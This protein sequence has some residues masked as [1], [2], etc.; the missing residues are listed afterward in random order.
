MIATRLL[1]KGVLKKQGFASIRAL[2]MALGGETFVKDII[3]GKSKDPG[4]LGV[5][6]IARALDIPLERL[7]EAI[8]ADRGGPKMKTKRGDKWR[9]LLE[10]IDEQTDAELF[11]AAEA[12]I[13]DHQG[14][15]GKRRKT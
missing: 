4:V 15:A 8:E 5:M 14:P 12:F 9:Q 11:Q 2:G 13:R 10:D 7:A 6:K 3:S 1:I